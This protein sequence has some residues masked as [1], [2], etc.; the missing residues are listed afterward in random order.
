MDEFCPL[1]ISLKK[2]N[3]EGENNVEEKKLNYVESYLEDGYLVLL[4]FHRIQ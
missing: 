2:I 1:A 4:V 3:I